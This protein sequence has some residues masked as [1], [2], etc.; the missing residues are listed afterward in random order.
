MIEPSTAEAIILDRL[1]GS[2]VARSLGLAIDSIE[3]RS[4]RLRLPFAAA[5]VTERTVIHG[6]VIATLAD[7]AAV[8]TAVSG[9][10]AVPSGG[11]TSSL[12]ITYLAPADG[13]DLIATG[14]ALRSG[15]RQHAVRVRI[16][17]NDGAPVAEALVQVVLE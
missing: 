2:P 11:A 13:C 7:V 5:N 1:L 14:I 6:G 16:A 3:P 10:K 12:S 8:A 4:V 15:S 17:G 9:A